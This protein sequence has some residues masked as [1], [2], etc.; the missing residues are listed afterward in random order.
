MSPCTISRVGGSWV[1]QSFDDE[2]TDSLETLENS[3]IT[4]RLMIW[5]DASFIQPHVKAL[6][7]LL[8]LSS[9]VLSDVLNILCFSVQ[10][11]G[12]ASGFCFQACFPIVYTRH[13][14]PMY[15]TL[16]MWVKSQPGRKQKKVDRLAHAHGGPLY[17]RLE[18]GHFLFSMVLPCLCI[19]NMPLRKENIQKLIELLYMNKHPEIVYRSNISISYVF[20]TEII[21]EMCLVAHITRA[22]FFFPL[23]I[24]ILLGITHLAWPFVSHFFKFM[25]GKHVKRCTLLHLYIFISLFLSCCTSCRISF[26]VLQPLWGNSFVPS[27]SSSF[28]VYLTSNVDVPRYTVKRCSVEVQ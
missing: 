13:F 11:D 12:A 26:S 23:W 7:S 5:E 22:P 18:H 9:V 25:M 6:V 17:C 21:N 10:I 27:L 8:K 1:S 3:P 14:I 2:V 20:V 15:R 24:F 16:G 19:L 28:I 4:M